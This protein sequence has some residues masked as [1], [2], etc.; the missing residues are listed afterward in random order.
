MGSLLTRMGQGGP[1]KVWGI[2]QVVPGLDCSSGSGTGIVQV[3]PR[4][5]GDCSSGS[6]NHLVSYG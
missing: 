2:V 3:V 5:D 6:L 1:E 4:R